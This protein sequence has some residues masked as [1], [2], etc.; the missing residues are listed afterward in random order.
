M[1]Q[2]IS[3]ESLIK[4]KNNG[5][6]NLTSDFVNSSKNKTGF[7]IKSFFKSNIKW[8]EILELIYDNSKIENEN[9]K[10]DAEKTTLNNQGRLKEVAYGNVLI[11]DDL[12]FSVDL[13]T[14]SN[15]MPSEINDIFNGLRSY[16]GSSTFTAG[17]G[18]LKVSI[19]SRFVTPHVDQWGAMIFQLTGQAV[20]TL[21]YPENGYEESFALEPGDFLHFPKGMFHS[22]ISTSA[23]SSII[24]PLSSNFYFKN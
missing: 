8:E 24:A 10:K 23:R 7:M 19:G 15:F 17:H 22:I 6:I 16:K 11:V 13:G 1:I 20:W 3:T 5:F 14:E 18:L 9:L 21:S 4:E 2:T 12:Y